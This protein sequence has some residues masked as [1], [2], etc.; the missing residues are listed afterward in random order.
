MIQFSTLDKIGN[1]PTLLSYFHLNRR[2]IKHINI[3]LT[4]QI[5]RLEINPPFYF[6]I[7]VGNMAYSLLYS[8]LIL[9][10]Y[11]QGSEIVILA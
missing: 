9:E 2:E 3:L 10:L 7:L 6:I 11:F 8:I 4:P 1:H 5:N